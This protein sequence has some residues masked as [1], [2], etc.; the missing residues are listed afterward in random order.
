[1]APSN[2]GGAASDGLFRLA[3]PFDTFSLASTLF[4]LPGAQVMPAPSVATYLP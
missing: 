4:I 1:V 3:L 2:D